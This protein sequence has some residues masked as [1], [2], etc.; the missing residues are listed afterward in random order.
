MGV[1]FEE[2]AISGLILVKPQVFSDERGF[3]LERYNK[4]IFKKNG[5]DVDFVQD[6]HSQS[7]KGVLRGLHFQVPPF[8]QDK[9][10]W[11][12]RGEVLDVAVDI[13]KNSPTFGKWESAVLSEVNR[14]MLFMPGGFAHGFLALSEK[15]DLS[16]KVSSYYCRECDRGIIWNDPDI[17]IAW[18]IENPVLSKKDALNKRL[19]DLGDVL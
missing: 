16:Y 15:V 7:R 5:I 1:I 12:V 4:K 8:A 11:V 6:N 19:K 17:G 13:R 2:L 3:F 18:G 9:L 10:V 14:Y